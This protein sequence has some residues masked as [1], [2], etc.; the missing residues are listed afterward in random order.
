MAVLTALAAANEQRAMAAEEAAA[1]TSLRNQEVCRPAADAMCKNSMPAA[2][3]LQLKALNGVL[4]QDDAKHARCQKCF[5][6]SCFFVG[7]NIQA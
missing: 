2:A 6:T 5:A 7:L 3:S 1:S 4:S